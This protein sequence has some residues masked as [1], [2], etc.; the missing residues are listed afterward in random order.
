MPELAQQFCHRAHHDWGPLASSFRTFLSTSKPLLLT[1]IPELADVWSH[2]DDSTQEDVGEFVGHLWCMANPPVIGGKFFHQ[3]RNG[4]LEE[5]EQ[6]PIN[7]IFPP[8]QVR[9][10]LEEIVNLWANEDEVLHLQR[11][12]QQPHRA[13]SGQY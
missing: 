10:S 9:A 1:D 12:E 2:F 4:I 7:L 3:R 13:C 5:R 11:F 6:V 8:G